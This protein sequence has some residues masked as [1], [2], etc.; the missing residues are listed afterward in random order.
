VR[1]GGVMGVDDQEGV[2]ARTRDGQLLYDALVPLGG[3]QDSAGDVSIFAPIIGVVFALVAARWVPPDAEPAD[4]TSLV[5]RAKTDLHGDV[6]LPAREAE[7]LLRASVWREVHLAANIDPQTMGDLQYELLWYMVRALGMSAGEISGLICEAEGYLASS[8]VPSE[9]TGEVLH[10]HLA[11]AAGHRPPRHN[12]GYEIRRPWREVP[13]GPDDDDGA[14]GPPP[15]GP[16]SILGLFFRGV[17]T[18]QP[19]REHWLRELKRTGNV[20]FGRGVL[21]IFLTAV[22]RRFRGKSTS[23]VAAFVKRL[24]EFYAHGPRFWP[25]EAEMLIRDA[26][27]ERVDIERMPAPVSETRLA[28]A[29]CIV[30]DLGLSL[31]QVDEL[32]VEAERLTERHGYPLTPA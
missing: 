26:L 22:R 31:K 17:V 7:A 13:V 14:H 25:L 10:L 27:G 5:Q 29:S 28:V 15:G 4:V 24:A 19:T 2:R 1:A 20:N 32:L 23:E 11:P 16:R 6:D 18:N 3:D 9:P 12:A 30:F 21:A 8:P